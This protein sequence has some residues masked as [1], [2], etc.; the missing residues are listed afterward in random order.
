[1]FEIA[2]WARMTT[3]RE[4]LTLLSARHPA[5][6]HI[7]YTQSLMSAAFIHIEELTIDEGRDLNLYGG[8]A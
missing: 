5:V 7:I 2:I 1:M 8:I 4:T 3:Q 6:I